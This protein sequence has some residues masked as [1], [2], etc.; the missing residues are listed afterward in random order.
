VEKG[1]KQHRI[2]KFGGQNGLPGLS[3][4]R[5][6]QIIALLKAICPKAYSCP[7]YEAVVPTTELVSEDESALYLFGD[8][9]EYR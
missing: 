8:Y 2:V 5:K 9:M 7:S 1:F 3:I 6:Y 4:K